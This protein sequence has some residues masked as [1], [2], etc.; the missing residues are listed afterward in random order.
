MSGYDG[1]RVLEAIRAVNAAQT[2]QDII[3]HTVSFTAHYGFSRILIGQLVSPASVPYKDILF[4]TNWPEE[5]QAER[6]EKFAIHHDP[7]AKCA[8]RSTRPFRWDEAMKFATR[9]G[10]KIV[11]MTA[12]Y[13]MTDGYTFPIH[14]L[15]SVPGGVSLGG[16]KLELSPT[17]LREVEIFV[18][19]VYVKLEEIEGPFPYQEVVDL[20]DREAEVVQFVAAGKTNPEIAS[21]LGIR[22]D[23]VNK[24]LQRVSKKLNTTNRA[25][26]VAQAIAKRQIFG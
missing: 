13:Q 10:R 9:T 18:Q 25:H 26:T 19:S 2:K 11:E 5:L 21:I 14:G 16:Q 1:A 17:E 12:N 23:T 6:M 3:S 20:T 24:T 7:I 15:Y 4:V 22:E 8:L